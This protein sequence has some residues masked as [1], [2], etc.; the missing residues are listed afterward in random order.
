MAIVKTRAINVYA[1]AHPSY[2][3]KQEGKSKTKEYEKMKRKKNLKNTKK[4]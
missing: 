3:R 1:Y 2:N 4:Q